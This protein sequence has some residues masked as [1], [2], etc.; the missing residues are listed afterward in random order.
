MSNQL[1]YPSNFDGKKWKSTDSTRRKSLPSYLR[2]DLPKKR[3]RSIKD[4]FQEMNMFSP[5]EITYFEG[6]IKR[7]FKATG[8][9]RPKQLQG[10]RKHFRA[11]KQQ[12]PQEELKTIKQGFTYSLM[13]TNPKSQVLMDILEQSEAKMSKITRQSSTERDSFERRL[14]SSQKDRNSH[15]GKPMNR[16]FKDTM[17]IVFSLK[18]R[19][20][21]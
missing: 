1:S 7:D 6:M 17:D 2:E 5:P 8:A 14:V 12:E 13:T 18:K 20:M 11:K 21:T 4:K 10:M 3:F 16:C 9:R 15:R 19:Q